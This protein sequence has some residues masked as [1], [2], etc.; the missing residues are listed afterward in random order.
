MHTLCITEPSSTCVQP[1]TYCHCLLPE[2]RLHLTLPPRKFLSFLEPSLTCSMPI[3][4]HLAGNQT[5]GNYC[6]LL[7]SSPSTWKPK[8]GPLPWLRHNSQVRQEIIL[9][10]SP[11]VPAQAPGKP[12]RIAHIT[13]AG[14][15]RA[16]MWTSWGQQQMEQLSALLWESAFTCAAGLQT[17]ATDAFVTTQEAESKICWQHT[18]MQFRANEHELPVKKYCHTFTDISPKSS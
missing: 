5:S 1:T 3:A 14:E 2:G 8:Q 11:N 10:S 16:L 15:H 12:G 9:S 7:N 4:E 6:T 17:Q 18:E 13:S